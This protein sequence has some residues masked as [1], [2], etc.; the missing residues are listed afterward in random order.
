MKI[1]EGINADH[2]MLIDENGVSLG[3]VSRD[4]ALYL[5]FEKGYD[6]V[7][8]NEYLNP[9][10]A[11]LMDY[12]KYLYSKQ[13][14]VSKQ[15]AQSHGAQLKEIRMGIKIDEHD[16][17]VKTNQAK[18]FLSRGDKV[19]VTVQLRGREMAF[20]NRVPSLIDR[21]IKL[22][23][24]KL[25]KP[26]DKMGNRFSIIITKATDSIKKKENNETENR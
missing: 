2:V 19:K 10:L 7:L 14:Q 22:T 25:E 21:I 23:N 9:P 3:K 4:Q 6:L 16:L 15:R 8:I 11:K 12:G 1:N 26:L 18:K 20:A 17:E 13:K 5:A 24:G